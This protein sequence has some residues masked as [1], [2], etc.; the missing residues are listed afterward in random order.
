MIYYGVSSPSSSRAIIHLVLL[1][2]GLVLAIGVSWSHFTQR[3]TGQQD[4][5]R[6][7]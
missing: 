3:L 6:V 7:A 5:D 4:T 1:A 2:I